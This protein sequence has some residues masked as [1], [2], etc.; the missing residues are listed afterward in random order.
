MQLEP[1]CLVGSVGFAAAR[2]AVVGAIRLCVADL[3]CVVV[4][5]LVGTAVVVGEAVGGTVGGVV[6]SN[7][8]PQSPL[9]YS[10]A[11]MLHFASHSPSPRQVDS[12]ALGQAP[13][14]ASFILCQQL[15]RH[16]L[17][18]FD[19]CMHTHRSFPPRRQRRV[20]ASDVTHCFV[21]VAASPSSH[22]TGSAAVVDGGAAFVGLTMISVVGT[23][24][25]VKLVAG[26]VVGLVVGLVV[27]PCGRM[28]QVNIQWGT[29]INLLG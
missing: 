17:T 21:F 19:S 14:R 24:A 1:G 28:V 18:E 6:R 7:E 8:L 13:H 11:A 15:P 27:M 29:Y 9:S 23:A 5:G 10:Q 22:T 2:V 4:V 3:R 26:R 16:C 20:S 12:H 25:R